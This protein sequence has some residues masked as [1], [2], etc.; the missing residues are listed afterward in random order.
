MFRY[1]FDVRTKEVEQ[2]KH[3][4]LQQIQQMYNQFISP[5]SKQRRRVAVHVVA[6]DQAAEL[7]THAMHQPYAALPLQD[8]TEL[9]D[10]KQKCH[11]Y[12][13]MVVNIP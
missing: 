12:P 7:S 4:T 11:T 13:P 1:V 5:S 2:L 10:F 3:V 9:D 6:K 8:V